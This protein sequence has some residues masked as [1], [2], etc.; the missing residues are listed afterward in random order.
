[1]KGLHTPETRAKI[2]RGLARYHVVRRKKASLQRERE[3]ELARIRPRDL[4]RLRRSG[5]VN[6]PLMPLLE[7][8]EAEAGELTAALGGPD[9][10]TPQ[11]RMLIEDATAV[12]I[13]LRAELGFYMQ[14]PNSDSAQRVGSLTNTRRQSLATLGLD[15]MA[16]E[17]PSLAEYLRQRETAQDRAHGENAGEEDADVAPVDERDAEA[18][19]AKPTHGQHLTDTRGDQWE[20]PSSSA[21]KP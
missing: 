19:E 3:Q 4:Q 5:T 18:N 14:N 9:A 12:G 8:A 1:M 6:A 2:S 17:V 13:V 20:R 21:L 7:I 15:R 16:R 10:V 11:R